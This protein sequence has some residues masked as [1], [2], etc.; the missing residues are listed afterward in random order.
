M[1]GSRGNFYVSSCAKKN[2]SFRHAQ[3]FLKIEVCE[4]Q[5]THHTI[6]RNHVRQ[7]TFFKRTY[8]NFA[9]KAL[10]AYKE[11]NTLE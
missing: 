9:E 2:I 10:V 8:S 11:L 7:Q 6:I 1:I 4:N 5:R 3:N